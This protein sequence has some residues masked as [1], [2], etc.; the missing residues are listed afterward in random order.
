MRGIS[1]EETSLHL[2]LAPVP[3]WKLPH[4]YRKSRNKPQLYS[5][6]RGKNPQTTIGPVF[7]F[8]EKTG[9]PHSAREEITHGN[10]D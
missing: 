3:D 5:Q 10:R 4:F 2:Y 9:S 1:F 8:V 7:S 6:A